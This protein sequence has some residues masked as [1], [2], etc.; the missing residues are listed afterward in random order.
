M[1]IEIGR[2]TLG[3]SSEVT[4]FVDRVDKTGELYYVRVSPRG[5]VLRLCLEDAQGQP[6]YREALEI[7]QMLG[8]VRGGPR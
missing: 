4:F 5:G 7:A 6:F 2:L 3:P 8:D 1:H